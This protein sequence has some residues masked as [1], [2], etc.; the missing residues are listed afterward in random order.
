MACLAILW[1]APNPEWTFE[2]HTLP[3]AQ[4]YT[5]KMYGMDTFEDETKPLEGMVVAIT[6]PTSGIGLELTKVLD[7]LGTSKILAIGRNPD[8]LQRLQQSCKSVEPIVADLSDLA[9][10]ANATDYI[11]E[12]YD[13][14]DMIINNAG[15]HT[16]LMGLLQHVTT[17]QGYDMT[18]GGRLTAQRG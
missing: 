16:V 17:K 9:S 4:E 8:K 11:V 3:L 13:R 7:S 10:V 12:H 14:L 6:G 5:E 15:I 18:F 1:S 2:Q